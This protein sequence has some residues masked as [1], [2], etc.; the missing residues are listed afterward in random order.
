MIRR[1]LD[2]A[3]VAEGHEAFAKGCR[4]TH[5]WCRAD[6]CSNRACMAGKVI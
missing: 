3:R 4:A 1:G 5:C 6:V 2:V